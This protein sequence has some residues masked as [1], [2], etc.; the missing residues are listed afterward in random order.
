[1][2][3]ATI[4]VVT[5]ISVMIKNTTIMV[6]EKAVKQKKLEILRK[7]DISGSLLPIEMAGIMAIALVAIKVTMGVA[8]I[9]VITT[10]IMVVV[11]IMVAILIP[12][13]ITMVTMMDAEQKCK[14]IITKTNI[15]GNTTVTVMVGT[16][17]TSIVV[18][19]NNDNHNYYNKGEEL[20]EEI[21]NSYWISCACY[22]I[23]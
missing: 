19:Q 8:I 16:M 4:I 6:I 11:T 20:N 22:R 18:T 14:V 1:M 7:V 10:A 13:I 23:R 15:N 3:V 21:S 2:V 12:N 17:V 5:I 9:M